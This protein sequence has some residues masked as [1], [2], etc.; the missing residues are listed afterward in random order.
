MPES[1][2]EIVQT[3][4]ALQECCRF[5]ATCPIIGLDTEFVGEESYHPRLCLVQVATPGRLFLIDPFSTGPLDNFWKL[6]LDPQRTVVVH[7]GR[8][9]VRLCRLWSGHSPPNLFDLQL[10]A[11]L[12]G[13][14]YPLGHGT[15][16]GQLLGTRLT[17]GETLTEWRRRPLTPEQIGYAFDDVRYLLRAHERLHQRLVRLDR[18]EWAREEFTRLAEIAGPND[19]LMEERW[20]KLKGVGSLDRKRLAAVRALYQWRE[21]RAAELNRPART[22]LRDDLIVEIARRNPTRARDLQVVRGVPNRDLDAIVN[23]ILDAREGNPEEFPERIERDQDPPQLAHV[24]GILMAV[25][26]DRCTRDKLASN[27]VACN[28]DLREL[29]RMRLARTELPDIPLAR[30]WRG[31]HILPDLLAVLDGRRLVR[32]ADPL[33]EAPLEYRE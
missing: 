6:L 32:I 28:N 12:V 2:E 23:V 10:A 15:L 24:A 9:E 18:V 29:V 13:L 19:P 22:I 11:G 3:A 14:P 20:R 7:A 31:K 33:A 26:G 4:E 5:L 17:K 21:D 27:L 16:I 1:T 8:E 30:G 25:L